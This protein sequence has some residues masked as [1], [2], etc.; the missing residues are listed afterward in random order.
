MVEKNVM[1]EIKME[2][3][4]VAVQVPVNYKLSNV[5]KQIIL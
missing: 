5:E 4:A 2:Q 3:L 1:I